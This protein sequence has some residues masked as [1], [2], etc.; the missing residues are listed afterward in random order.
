M[1]LYLGF[2]FGF[3]CRLGDL[4]IA[5]DRVNEIKQNTS[6]PGSIIA[7]LEI[8]GLCWGTR[9]EQ[10]FLVLEELRER[11]CKPDFITYYIVTEALRMADRL[12]ECT[13]F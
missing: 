6:F 2:L 4:R 10:D 11:S 9:I 12:D 13:R 8:N 7:T 1:L 3:F 5:L